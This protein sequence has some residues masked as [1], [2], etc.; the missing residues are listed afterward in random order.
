MTLG[1]LVGN[2]LLRHHHDF[3]LVCFFLSY[4]TVLCQRTVSSLLAYYGVPRRTSRKYHGLRGVED[5]RRACDELFVTRFDGGGRGQ[6]YTYCGGRGTTLELLQWNISSYNVC[7]FGNRPAEAFK[8]PFLKWTLLH[9]LISL[10]R[11][12]APEQGMLWESILRDVLL[13]HLV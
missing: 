9:A 6:Y 10:F 7:R 13:Y 5:S 4:C 1:W 8:F 11:E 3:L 2:V 12:T